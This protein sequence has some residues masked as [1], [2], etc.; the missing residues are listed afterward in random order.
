M[1]AFPSCSMNCNMGSG[2]VKVRINENSFDFRELGLAIK[3]AREKQNMTQKKLAELLD[4]SERHISAVEN[5]GQHPS[6]QML[7]ELVTMFH[8][9]LDPFFSPEQENK[10]V[11]RRQLE[12]RLDG[13]TDY[14]LL[15]LDGTIDGIVKAKKAED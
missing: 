15:V 11:R 2:D 4:V 7:Y 9:R 1:A 8:I 10:S 12:S 13:L 14:D 3:E 6:L 5:E